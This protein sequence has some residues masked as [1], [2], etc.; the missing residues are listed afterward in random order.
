M[1][2][3]SITFSL[4]G[5][6]LLWRRW[7]RTWAGSR[8]PLQC[9]CGN[10]SSGCGGCISAASAPTS[11]AAKPAGLKSAQSR[12]GLTNGEGRSHTEMP[13]VILWEDLRVLWSSDYFTLILQYFDAFMVA[14]SIFIFAMFSSRKVRI[15]AKTR[16][17][18]TLL[19]FSSFLICCLV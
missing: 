17:W 8:V 5:C 13:A 11:G 14:V 18:G 2:P 9:G 6:L 10:R 3:A 16:L 7:G 4:R 1:Q 12:H 15:R 19:G